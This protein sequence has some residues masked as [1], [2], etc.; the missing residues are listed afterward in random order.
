MTAIKLAGPGVSTFGIL[1]DYQD[2]GNFYYLYINGDGHAGI[3]IIQ[4]GLRSNID[5]TNVMPAVNVGDAKN[6]LRADCVYDK[7]VGQNILTL[8]ANGIPLLTNTNKVFKA[9]IVGLMAVSL[10]AEGIDIRFDDFQVFE[11]IQP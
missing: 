8:F 6:Q 4:D 1:C 2:A 3:D 7:K 11:I 5:S 10:G 9:G